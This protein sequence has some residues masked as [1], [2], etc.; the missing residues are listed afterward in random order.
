MRPKLR[1]LTLLC[2]AVLFIVPV[3]SSCRGGEE[4]LTVGSISERIRAEIS[5]PKMIE[6]SPE[7]LSS[8]FN[9]SADSFSDFSVYISD[10]DEKADEYAVFEMKKDTDET[11]VF[12]AISIHIAD[13]SSNF[14]QFPPE[15]E[16]FQTN[17]LRSKDRFLMLVV[18]G[19]AERASELLE[20]MG[21]VPVA[22][23]N[24]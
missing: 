13:R 11:E 15:Y 22:A 18:C 3:L 14:R 16:K 17:V 24:K 1:F 2:V 4:E 6:L 21:A 10:E 9:L 7:Q 23:T 12:N 8:H 5:F 19:D 20:S